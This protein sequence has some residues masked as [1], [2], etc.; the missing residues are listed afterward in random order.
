MIGTLKREIDEG[1]EGFELEREARLALFNYI[2]AYCN[3]QRKHSA[4]NYQTPSQFERE[5]AAA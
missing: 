4:L 2:D 5:A 1:E 3:T